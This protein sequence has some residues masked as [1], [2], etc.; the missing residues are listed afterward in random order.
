MRSLLQ[1]PW[2][3]AVFLP[4]KAHLSLSLSLSP[5]LD[6]GVGVTTVSPAHPFCVELSG[7]APGN[8]TPWVPASWV[9]PLGLRYHH[10]SILQ[11]RKPRPREVNECASG[12]PAPL[13]WSWGSYLL[14]LRACA[15][16]H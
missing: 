8:G 6:D 7:V 1:A 12:H 10:M 15:L 2:S 5:G 16:D 9:R 4:H 13:M 14:G 11:M 3:S